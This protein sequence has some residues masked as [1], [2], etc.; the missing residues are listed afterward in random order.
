VIAKATSATATLTSS[1]NPVFASNATTLTATIASPA[2]T[3]TGTVT[4]LDGATPIGT[5]TLSAGGV[6][7]LTISTLAAGSHSITASYG[8]DTNFAPIV[9]GALTQVVQDFSLA[10]SPASITALPSGTAV[11]TVTAA[12]LNGA[13]FPAAV[14]LSVSGLPAG[15][16]STFS[17]ASITAGLGSTPVTLTI[18]VPATVAGIRP[19]TDHNGPQLAANNHGNTG[20]SIVGKLA[21][22]SLALI[23]LPF[24]GRLRR[25]GKRMGRMLSILLLLT[26][27]MAA[28]AGISACGSNV[29]IFA[30]QPQSYTVNV[31]GTA[32]ALTHSATAT[33]TVE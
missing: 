24:A 27:G 31:T 28:V 3:P 19:L 7:T 16:T 6:A 13:T 9:S 2:G 17:P 11:Y 4:F 29:G 20:T 5:G 12:P 23:L 30:Q 8:G 25:N 14:A 26:A 32:G 18:V 15:A 22:F 33:L 10:M 1:V 21:P